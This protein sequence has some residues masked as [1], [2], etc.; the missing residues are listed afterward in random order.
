MIL[1]VTGTLPVFLEPATFH[2]NLYRPSTS[3]SCAQNCEMYSDPV[4]Q[5]ICFPTTA[6]SC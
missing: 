5:M 3:V 6:R 1:S 2:F 4:D